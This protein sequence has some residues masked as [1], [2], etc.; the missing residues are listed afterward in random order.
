MG[1]CGVFFVCLFV[2]RKYVVLD[3]I[4]VA[5]ESG[6]FCDHNTNLLLLC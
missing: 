3:E 6:V 2:L 5:N 4:S 1:L